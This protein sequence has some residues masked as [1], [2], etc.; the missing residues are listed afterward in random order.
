MMKKILDSF[1]ITIT[2]VT[3]FKVNKY[4]DKYGDDPDKGIFSKYY[5]F[6]QPDQNIPPVQKKEAYFFCEII[7]HKYRYS[8]DG[9]YGIWYMCGLFV[10]VTVRSG[11][12]FTS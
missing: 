8:L 5:A 11:R 9:K 12:P 1:F 3:M 6:S 10:P 7:N 2:E 4:F